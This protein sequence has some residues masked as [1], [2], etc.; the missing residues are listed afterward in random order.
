MQ[1]IYLRHISDKILSVGILPSHRPHDAS[2][3]RALHTHRK[4]VQDTAHHD[5][6]TVEVILQHR[7]Q[8]GSQTCDGHGVGFN[9]TRGYKNN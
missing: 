2:A 1:K 5:G 7:R 3:G 4:T 6:D 8:G 9:L